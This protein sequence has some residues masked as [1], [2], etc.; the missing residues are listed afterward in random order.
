MVDEARSLIFEETESVEALKVVLAQRGVIP[1][2]GAEAE[3][4]IKEA[5]DG[6][7]RVQIRFIRGDAIPVSYRFSEP[8]IA[9][10]LVFYC[11]NLG[12]P[13]PKS[14]KKNVRNLDGRLGLVVTLKTGADM[15]SVDDTAELGEESAVDPAGQST[16]A[17]GKA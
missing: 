16:G 17:G 12:I 7:V 11:I 14:G 6:S 4:G 13:L 10:A 2:D 3:F 8:E 5:R 15:D 1:P 9:A